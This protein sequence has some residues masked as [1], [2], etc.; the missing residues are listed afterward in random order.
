MAIV[1]MSGGAI[2]MQQAR[3]R[4]ISGWLLSDQFFGK[5]VVKIGDQHRLRL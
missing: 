2:E 1:E 4:T 5:M 3:G